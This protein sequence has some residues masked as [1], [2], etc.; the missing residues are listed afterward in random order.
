MRNDFEKSVSVQLG[1]F[2]VYFT[3]EAIAIQVT[4]TCAHSQ[5]CTSNEQ[6]VRAIMSKSA[7][8]H[9]YEV[10][11]NDLYLIIPLQESDDPTTVLMQLTELL[12]LYA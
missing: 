3:D 1:L 9:S 8:S 10:V 5:S 7:V 12:D 4:N 6:R 2:T 11:A